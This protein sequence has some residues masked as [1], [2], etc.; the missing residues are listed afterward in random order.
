MTK[1][2]LIKNFIIVALVSSGIYLWNSFSGK[3]S[4][5]HIW[6]ILPYFAIFTPLLHLWLLRNPDPKKFVMRYM[7]ATGI[8][9]LINLFLI[10]IYGLINKPGAVTFAMAFLVIYFI[11]TFFEI[12]QLL[13]NPENKLS[14]SQKTNDV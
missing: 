2:Y 6:F 1:I 10:L 14:N 8:K 13:K 3:F 12:S 9:L 4:N 11:F 5:I 7:G